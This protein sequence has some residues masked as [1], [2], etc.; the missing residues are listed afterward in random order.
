MPNWCEGTLKVRGTAENIIR[1]IE[2]GLNVYT[3]H[4]DQ[5]TNKY[6]TDLVPKEKWLS[7][8]VFADFYDEHSYEFNQDCYVEETKRAFIKADS[9]I[10]VFCL[11]NRVNT[12]I[13]DFQ[14]AWDINIEDWVKLS[15]KYNLD[16]RLYGIESGAEFCRE[17]EII[18]GEVTIDKDIEYDDWDWECPFPRMGG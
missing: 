3:G 4:I 9:R 11:D 18:S 13:F 14:Q 10:H 5:E 2:N 15:K 6:I 1:F 17:V 16:F 7:E 12:I 8:N